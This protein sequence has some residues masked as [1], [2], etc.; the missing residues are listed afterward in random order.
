MLIIDGTDLVGKTTLQQ[1]LVSCL[2]SYGP[3]I[4]AHFTR[5]PV[6]WKHPVSYF[7]RMSRYIV[8]DRF[9]MSELAYAFACG[10]ETDLTAFGYNQVD[11]KLR[12]LGGFTVVITASDE[13]LESQWAPHNRDEMYD[14][15]TIKRANEAFGKLA[16]NDWKDY[17]IDCDLNIHVQKGSEF[18]SSRRDVVDRI[19]ERYMERQDQLD[20]INKSLHS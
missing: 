9:H 8:Q 3:W 18:P 2:A 16:S 7:P 11:A 17:N 5:L 12:Q 6:G 1:K 20:A 14:L 10:R 4:S 13:F 15:T 19:I